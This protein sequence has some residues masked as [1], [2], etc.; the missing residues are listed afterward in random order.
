MRIELAFSMKDDNEG[1]SFLFIDMDD[2][3]EDLDKRARF[4][5]LVEE[6]ILDGIDTYIEE[7]VKED[8]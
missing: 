4:L 8:K 6:Y 5:E 3:V 2:I 7:Y 1:V